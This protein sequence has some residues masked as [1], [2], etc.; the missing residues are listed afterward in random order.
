MFQTVLDF[1]YESIYSARILAC[2]FIF[3]H[4]FLEK[5]SRIP[6]VSEGI[7]TAV[8][9]FGGCFSPFVNYIKTFPEITEW[10]TLIHVF[11]YSFLLVLFFAVLVVCHKGKIGDYLY[12]FACGCL[13]EC[14]IF[15]YFRLFYDAG[16]F[17]LRV[18]TPLSIL[19]E[20]GISVAVCTALFFVLR[21]FEKRREIDE[22]VR[23]PWIMLYFFGTV[24]FNM[25]LRLKL[26][27][28][29]EEVRQT[30]NGWVINFVLGTVPLFLLITDVAIMRAET[31]KNEKALLN[32]M[33]TEKQKQYAFSKQ[34][35]DAI[36]RKCHDIKRQLRALD[37]MNE[38]GRGKAIK[39]MEQTVSIYDSQVKT[40]NGALDTL[41]S[42]KG[43]YC[44]SHGIRLNNM[45]D[46]KAVKCLDPVEIY[47]MFGNL[48]DNAI[49]AVEKIEEDGKRVIDF[50]A[51]EKSGVLIVQTDNYFS[52]DIQLENGMPVTSKTD[53][54]L[55]GYGVKSIRHIAERHG[56]SMKIRTNGEIFTVTATIPLSG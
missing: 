43:F 27:Q 40:E 50:K 51:V 34:T 19:V 24:A 25:F 21:S 13:L 7:I 37:F 45:V 18:N 12:V 28:T 47:T 15:G 1:I 20:I 39:E 8:V 32:L 54:N 46:E 4:F 36:N 33:L 10:M 14:T 42:E 11:W 23:S 52:G 22:S 29:Y 38:E 48:I 31:L 17:E 41:L 5:R 2:V 44:A 3:S 30:A 56:G 53:K 26:Q 49:E 6:F 55:H 16:V 35:V 9:L